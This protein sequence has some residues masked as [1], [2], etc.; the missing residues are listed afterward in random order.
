MLNSKQV[1]QSSSLGGTSS[2]EFEGLP[3]EVFE[4][5]NEKSQAID[6][7]ESEGE[8]LPQENCDLKRSVDLQKHYQKILEECYEEASEL[9]TKKQTLAGKVKGL[10]AELQRKTKKLIENTDY[11]IGVWNGT[12][13]ESNDDDNVTAIKLR[14]SDGLYCKIR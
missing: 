12:D 14:E 7:L 5:I 13:S 8:K 1:V 3:E 9:T 6:S 4:V 11:E 10:E 2:Y